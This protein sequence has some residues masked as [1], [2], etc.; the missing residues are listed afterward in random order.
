MIK[1]SNIRFIMS[2]SASTWGVSFITVTS[3]THCLSSS[4]MAVMWLP[5]RTTTLSMSSAFAAWLSRRT[6]RVS[7][8]NTRNNSFPRFVHGGFYF[9]CP[10]EF[11]YL[12]FN[13]EERGKDYAADLT[14]LVLRVDGT[15]FPSMI[16]SASPYSPRWSYK[17]LLLKIP[18][19]NRSEG[20]IFLGSEQLAGSDYHHSWRLEGRYYEEIRQ[21]AD[22]QLQKY[23]IYAKNEIKV[24]KYCAASSVSILRST[25][26]TCHLSCMH[27]L[28]HHSALYIFL[29]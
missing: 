7:Q 4:I 2:A 3:N 29:C 27:S 17:D 9:F 28:L 1:L 18:W 26:I 5:K 23:S 24:R 12:N 16:I 11:G 10:K 25:L 8:F 22:F 15:L 14:I 6:R 20:L 19:H 21:Q 13:W